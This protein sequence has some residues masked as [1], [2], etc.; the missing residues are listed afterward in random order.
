MNHI[1]KNLIKI[2]AGIGFCVISNLIDPISQ[3]KANACIPSGQDDLSGGS[4]YVT[5]A[6]YKIKVYEMGLC[7]SDPLSGTYINDSDEVVTNNT[8]D[9]STCTKTFESASGY[10][11]DL[12][13]NAS[14]SLVG[15]SFR[16]EPGTYPSAY[17]KIKNT[18]TMKGSY[19]LGG[20]PYF[21]MA[22]SG[23][24]NVTTTE[25]DNTEFDEP[26]MDFSSG[27]TCES[28]ESDRAMAGSE[29]FN[30]GVT[31]TMKA[32][33]ATVNGS[34]NYVGTSSADCG[35]STHLYG[36]FSPTSPVVITDGTQGLE[37]TFTVTQRGMTIH[38][39]G[40]DNTVI[41]NFSSGPFSPAF[42]TF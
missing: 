11:V 21:S 39:A 30:S 31:G 13:G 14:S 22:Y 34:G 18:F 4:C 10:T 19:T 6:T 35:T 17:I 33:L 15:T 2:S 26:L 16:P 7:T 25:A 41:G 37:V 32:V 40:G 38:Q 9:E 29:V 8:I 5:P 28:T 1:N 27:R 20:T 3:V 36:A 23:N 42:K 12:G 24:N